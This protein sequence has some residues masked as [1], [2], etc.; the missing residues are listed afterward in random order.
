MRNSMN[1]AR[2][3][4]LVFVAC[5]AQLTTAAPAWASYRVM[6]QP[7]VSDAIRRPGGSI[8]AAAAANAATPSPATVAVPGVAPATA[9]AATPGA[10]APGAAG[11]TD[12]VAANGRKLG[13][14]TSLPQFE[15]AM[16]YEP[17]SPNY[18]VSFALE[19]ADLTEIVKIIGQMTG[20]R[21]IF[22]KVR[23]GIKA[24]VYSP[25]KV[26]VAEAYQAFLSIL[27]AN[28]LTVIP[29][30]RFYKI[31]DNA[32]VQTQP[33]PLY[34]PGQTVPAEERYVTRM[35]RLSH[36][37]ADDATAL[38]NNFKS[39]D[40][41]VTP[42]AQSGMVIMTDTGTN[43]RRMMHIL[44]SVDL[45]SAQDQ[46]WIEK[47]NY[48]PATEAVTRINELFDVKSGGAAA[49]GGKPGAP[50]AG[51]D[52]HI[53]KVLADERTNSLV[54]VATERSY[55]RMLEFIK[56][57]DVMQTGEG[58][59]HVLPL[60]HAEAVDLQKVLADIV[61]QSSG[62]AR[63]G[64]PGAGGAAAPVGI[65]EGQVRISADK[66]TNSLVITSSPRD[67]GA[68]RVVLDRL[69]Q[70]RRQVFID[71]VIMDVS[72]SRSE[73]IG[74]GLHGGAPVDGSNFLAGFNA[75]DSISLVPAE[76][77][78]NAA[79]GIRGPV[80]PGTANLI[81]GLSAGI[82]SFGLTLNLIASSGSTDILSTPHI[83]ATDN[84]PAEI[85][86]GVNLA[87]QQN[88]QLGSLA[89]LAGGAGGAAAGLLGSLGGGLGSTPLRQ[90]VG[91]KIKIIPHLNESNEARLEITED[92]QDT[93]PRDET[94]NSVPIVKRSASTTLIV[95][96]QQTVVIGG[97]MRN[98]VRRSKSKVPILGD[99][100][101]LGALFSR[102][103]EQ[104]EKSNLLLVITPTI[105]R[106]QDDL[107]KV[108]QRKM[109]E[110]QDLLDRYF[111]F[112]EDQKYVPPRDYSR[113]NGLLEDIRQAYV[114]VEE[115][116]AIEELTK[117]KELK[118]HTRGIPLEMPAAPRAGAGAAGGG[119]PG[120][121]AAAAVPGTAP[122]INV[123]Q[124]T[125]GLD[126]VER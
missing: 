21:F 34:G 59:I 35:H 31:V 53:S 102:T 98:V 43:V 45:G 36:M 107:R 42:V 18:R 48:V 17:R 60:Q 52:V 124:P 109:E 50:P 12:A 67:Y 99:I 92:I 73:N 55:L 7:R 121:P 95:K 30:G 74:F 13:D 15:N 25:Q 117:P 20:K 26:T 41:T 66:A 101:I 93:G 62:G 70:P 56:R 68:L 108:F 76:A 103:T 78:N 3:C 40:G 86:I 116:R 8:A 81:P 104:I 39:K 33:T 69:D 79:V 80:I 4:P 123:Q 63:G 61:G 89:G 29:Q 46:I 49:A 19:D 119:Q 11:A 44:S 57:I 28:G 120:I 23:S 91:T 85:N 72:V 5:A 16:E 112:S 64:A 32:G 118:T 51:G 22:G 10:T 71:A 84:V 9:G 75:K 88:N 14:T 47:L 1:Y 94:F 97:L 2:I 82:P 110:R 126:R 77:L 24:T 106:E 96:D 113:T 111:V 27:E 58:E 125:R 105:I 65:F 54:I 38:L 83:L 122:M 115:K 114:Q 6:G 100:P 87:V 90:D 37:G